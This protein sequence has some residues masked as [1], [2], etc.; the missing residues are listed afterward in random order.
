MGRLFRWFS[1]PIIAVQDSEKAHSR[2]LL[3]LRFASSNPMFRWVL[4]LLYKP[5]KSLKIHCF[6]LDYDHPFGLAAGMDK[7][8]EA[9]RGWESI[10][11]AFSEIGGVTMHEQ[12]GNPKPRMFRHGA[13]RALVNRM[14]FNNPGSEKIVTTLE[15]AG[16]QN[17]PVWANLGK[18]KITPLEE[19]RFDYST[20][21]KRMWPFVDVFVVNVSSPNTPGLRDL[22]H[23]DHLT[24]ILDSC[25]EVNQQCADLYGK[26]RKPI[27]IK[28]APDLSNEEL[29]AIVDAAI[30]SQ[31]DGIVATNTTLSRPNKEHPVYIE[32]GGC[33]GLPLKDRS[34]DMIRHIYAYTEGQL[35]IV[36]V[37]GIM[38]ADDAW[39]KITAG[40]SLLQ[41]YA[42]FVFEGP[43]LTKSI[44]HGLHKKL[45][46]SEFES[47]DEAIGAYHR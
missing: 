42:G 25:I 15:K 22:Q 28:V 27:L 26:T 6:G 18:S 31:I 46:D 43:S 13:D 11:L 47:I 38:N 41:A 10:G 45:R 4:R 35:P 5:K 19:A 23:G 30:Q 29:E 9:L 1:R 12:G 7:K 8:A 2:S 44:V 24:G 17:I 40:A 36:G 16:K 20:S 32:Q 37:G 34:T 21:L 33:S 3:M 39:E 14:G